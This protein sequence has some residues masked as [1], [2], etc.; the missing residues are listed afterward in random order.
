MARESGRGFVARGRHHC[1][2]KGG[3]GGDEDG[4]ERGGIDGS[5]LAGAVGERDKGRLARRLG[6]RGD[7]LG[8][9]E[10]TLSLVRAG[11][12]TTVYETNKGCLPISC[13]DET[14]I[15]HNVGRED[16][17]RATQTCVEIY[18]HRRVGGSLPGKD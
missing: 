3:V 10:E 12:C 7:G 6:G 16:T 11:R 2:S 14:P 4:D 13:V 18:Q 1:R 8:D 15:V 5:G 9:G 17:D